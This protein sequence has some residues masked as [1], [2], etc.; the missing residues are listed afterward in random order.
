LEGRPGQCR[1]CRQHRDFLVFVLSDFRYKYPYLDFLEQKPRKTKRITSRR[2]WH[3]IAS[4]FELSYLIDSIEDWK[5]ILPCVHT[6]TT[7]LVCRT[8]LLN[9]AHFRMSRIIATH[10][11]CSFASPRG[12]DAATGQRGHDGSPRI[13][14]RRCH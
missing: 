9:M 14:Q 11:E 8:Q 13:T 7:P 5:S 6:T 12:H 2:I 3:R 1:R 10:H 4:I